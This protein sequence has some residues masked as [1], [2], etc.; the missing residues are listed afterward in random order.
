[1][2]FFIWFFSVGQAFAFY[3]LVASNRGSW[4][5]SGCPTRDCIRGRHLQMMVADEPGVGMT[6]HD[7]STP[8]RP[9]PQTPVNGV[10]RMTIAV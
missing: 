7:V 5:R 2:S 4:G 8:L 10:P 3:P 9:R 6:V 1:V